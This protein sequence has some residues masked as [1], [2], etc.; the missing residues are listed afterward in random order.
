MSDAAS[1]EHSSPPG[2]FPQVVGFGKLAR[3][4][5]L[6]LRHPLYNG[7]P[8]HEGRPKTRSRGCLDEEAMTAGQVTVG[9]L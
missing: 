9:L 1:K 8:Q 3:H 5:R 6:A 4:P 2:A 7:L